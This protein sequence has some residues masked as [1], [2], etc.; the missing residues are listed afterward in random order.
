MY[1]RTGHPAAITKCPNSPLN[2]PIPASVANLRRPFV[3]CFILAQGPLAKG[4][5]VGLNNTSGANNYPLRGGKIGV[6]EGGIRVNAFVSGGLVPAALA[7]TK[8]E[9]F[10]HICDWRVPFTPVLA[11]CCALP[12]D[13]HSNPHASN[14]HA[15]GSPP[16]TN[17]PLSQVRDLL[18]TAE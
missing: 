5:I 15:D 17:S 1:R 6:M 7:G 11:S 3:P 13:A 12:I 18:P 14:P 9:E 2:P 4:D 10:V 8:S 16:A